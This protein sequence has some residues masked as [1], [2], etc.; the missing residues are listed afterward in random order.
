MGA[1]SWSGSD[2]VIYIFLA[3]M[4]T[5]Q[6]LLITQTR[7]QESENM[8]LSTALN[9]LV[10]LLATSVVAAPVN[11]DGSLV[12]FLMFCRRWSRG[13]FVDTLY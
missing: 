1:T 3:A 2:V 4:I 7:Y 10:L 13:P 6:Q 11:V 5:H 8:Q 9:A 12:R